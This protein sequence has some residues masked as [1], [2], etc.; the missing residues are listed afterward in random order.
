M[1][2][3]VPPGLAHANDYRA[4]PALGPGA[5]W[6]TRQLKH[7]YKKLNNATTPKYCYQLPAE[8]FSVQYA[9]I[10]FYPS[11]IESLMRPN[12]RRK[13][14]LLSRLPYATDNS[15]ILQPI[16]RV[17]LSSDVEV[18]PGPNEDI[19]QRKSKQTNVQCKGK[20]NVG[21]KICEWNINRLTD[22]K[23]EQIRHFLTSSHPE[24]D[25][26][27]LIETFLKPKVPDSVFEIPGYVMYRKDRPVVKQGG[28][29][30]AY[31]NFK[32]KENHRIDLEEK[33]IETLWL[34]IF[35]FN[36]KRPLLVG[37]LYRPPSSNVDIDSRIEKNIENAYLQNREAIIVG[38][39]KINYFNGSCLL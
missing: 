3:T 23:F 33:E 6:K 39:F 22:S 1:D 19:A 27:F 2:D 30:L 21:L 37:A 20:T 13:Y 25:V 36:S 11:R 16:R 15:R 18:N 28:G 38:D 24:I 29:I 5:L 7:S 14:Y 26:L 31:V 12:T 35:P 10:G 17:I 9:F 8:S 34:V 4:V 32:L